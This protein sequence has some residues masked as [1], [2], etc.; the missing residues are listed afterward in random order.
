MSSGT[1]ARRINRGSSSCTMLTTILFSMLAALVS[2]ALC[3]ISARLRE[4][5]RKEHSEFRFSTGSRAFSWIFTS[6]ALVGLTAAMSGDRCLPVTA[7]SLL[8]AGCAAILG[9]AGCV[10]TDRFALKFFDDHLTYGAFRT[11]RVDYKGIVSSR[12]VRGGKGRSRLLI[13]T[14]RKTISISVDSIGE[15]TQVLQGKLG[16]VR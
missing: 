4:P 7:S 9:F 6:A 5:R 15:A 12:L 1:G 2:A 10:W 14:S 13:K 16:A 3:L 8:F 11:A